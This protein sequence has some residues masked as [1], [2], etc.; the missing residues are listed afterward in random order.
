[1]TLTK[2]RLSSFGLTDI[3]LVRDQNEDVWNALEEF[4]FFCPR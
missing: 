4:G 3:G 1:M 2:Y